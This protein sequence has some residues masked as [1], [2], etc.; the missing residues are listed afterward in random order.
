[1]IRQQDTYRLSDE[2][3]NSSSPISH[4]QSVFAI[5]GLGGKEST[6][7]VSVTGNLGEE[8]LLDL[9]ERALRFGG[10]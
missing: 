3:V 6:N 9:L 4:S 5:T 10:I 7:K 1:M 8:I 2:L